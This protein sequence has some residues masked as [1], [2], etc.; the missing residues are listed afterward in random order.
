MCYG[1]QAGTR[2]IWLMHGTADA[3]FEL[4]RYDSSSNTWTPRAQM[5]QTDT[6]VG[7]GGALAYVA[8]PFAYPTASGWIF[9][10]K[11]NRSHQFY[12]YGVT[13][14]TWQ[15]APPIP[16]SVTEG[17]ALCFGGYHSRGGLYCADIYAFTGSENG[18]HQGRFFR[19]SIP[20]SPSLSPIGGFWTELSPLTILGDSYTVNAGAALAWYNVPGT[21]Q[22]AV[23]ALIAGNT[24]NDGQWLFKYDPVANAWGGEFEF[25]HAVVQGGAMTSGVGDTLWCFRG[26]NG[27]TWWLYDIRTHDT[28]YYRTSP[29]YTW[30]PQNYGAAMCFNGSNVYA[31]VGAGE[32]GFRRFDPPADGSPDGG[33]EQGHAVG[34]GC[35]L[36]VTVRAGQN[37][38]AFCV[39]NAAP[40]PVTLRI[41]DAS[42]RTVGSVQARALAQT[43][44]LVW[45]SGAVNSGVYFYSVETPGARASGKFVIAR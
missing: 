33:G 31:E 5:P 12:R 1:M 22:G 42:G 29:N 26:G 16:D 34:I 6:S 23:Y 7:R 11:G 21:S 35:P 37:A 4:H 14:N 9:A 24:G 30:G 20:L 43:V 27:R 17:G 45:N 28:T 18:R 44:E 13:A 36:S 40:G 2:Y 41:A 10:L 8:D 15:S 19:Y 32:G 39:A 25:R 3:A 38:H